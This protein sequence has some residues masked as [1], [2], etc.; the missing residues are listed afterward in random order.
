MI[1]RSSTPTWSDGGRQ[2]IAFVGDGHRLDEGIGIVV[3]KEDDAL[4]IRLNRAIE[5]ILADGSYEKINA[6]YFPFSIY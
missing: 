6:R 4:R 3:R 5:A 1:R 2:T